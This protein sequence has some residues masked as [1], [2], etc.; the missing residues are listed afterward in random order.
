MLLVSEGMG[1]AMRMVGRRLAQVGML[2][3]SIPPLGKEMVAVQMMHKHPMEPLSNW[4]MS[5][6]LGATI[7]WAWMNQTT[8]ESLT[9]MPMPKTKK[10]S[11]KLAKLCIITLRV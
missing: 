9:E 10:R 3:D 5:L 7:H 6:R 11:L 8:L 2:E 1:G 4:C